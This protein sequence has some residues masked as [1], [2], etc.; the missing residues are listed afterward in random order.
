MLKL[1]NGRF[2]SFLKPD[3]VFIK[4]SPEGGKAVAVAKYFGIGP[5]GELKGISEE[6]IRITF[7]WLGSIKGF[8]F[9]SE[10]EILKRLEGYISKI[11]NGG[12]GR[13]EFV[14]TFG[15]EVNYAVSRDQLEH[16]HSVVQKTSE[17][18]RSVED[19]KKLLF[20]LEEELDDLMREIKNKIALAE[21]VD[22]Q[23]LKEIAE[24]S[25]KTFAERVKERHGVNR[26][27]E[28]LTVKVLPFP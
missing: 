23:K 21:V 16:F 22:E 8:L 3:R 19:L 7:P 6:A 28:L 11:R 1:Y 17:Q 25:L 26:I 5:A 27:E 15:E 12:L 18:T 10:E 14:K 9:D 2:E 24:E 4:D 20:K 13:E